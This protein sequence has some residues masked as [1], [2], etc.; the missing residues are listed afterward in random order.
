MYGGAIHLWEN[1]LLVL[2]R[3][4]AIE[5]TLERSQQIVAWT[6]YDHH[7]KII[8]RLE[9]PDPMGYRLFIPPRAAL[10][11]ALQHAAEREGVEVVTSST[12]LS[13]TRDGTVAL[14]NGET[15]KADLVVA[16]DGYRSRIRESLGLTKTIE[17]HRGASTRMMVPTSVWN[18]INAVDTHMSTRDSYDAGIMLGAASSELTYV[19]I[20]GHHT[21]VRNSQIPLDKDYWVKAFPSHS[22][23]MEAVAD[24][25]R[26][27]G[28]ARRDQHLQVTCKAWSAGRVAIVGDAA[29]AM[30]PYL[31][32][33]AN[34]SLQNGLGLAVALDGA[35]D[36]PAALQAW[37]KRERPLADHVQR[38]TKFLGTLSEDWP[39]GLLRPQ[40]A[41]ATDK[42]KWI[43]KQL[44]RAE[45]STPT[46]TEELAEARR[47]AREARDAGYP[48]P[49][50]QAR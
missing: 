3:L 24:L 10:N 40:I 13:A 12:G 6:Y 15:V 4:G 36:I 20:F 43:S 27:P 47:R 21:N 33:G 22:G 18:P 31:G 23:L 37:E 34:L 8:Q 7:G 2:E 29:H 11:Q 38:W 9:Y 1:G 19:S 39:R 45:L 41:R 14:E 42:S 17:G 35:Q 28:F 16:A 44:A 30:S 32:Q 25:S 26:E 46:G 50:A 5:E 49:A 48:T